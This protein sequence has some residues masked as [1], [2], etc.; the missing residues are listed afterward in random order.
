METE[1][2]TILVNM[3]DCSNRLFTFKNNEIIKCKRISDEKAKDDILYYKL[4]D[5]IQNKIAVFLNPRAF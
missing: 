4:P 1:L 5:E 3:P 2:K